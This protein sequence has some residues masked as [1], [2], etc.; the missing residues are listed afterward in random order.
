MTTTAM[1]HCESY[2]QH[3]PNSAG[4]DSGGEGEIRREI[5]REGGRQRKRGQVEK[6]RQPWNARPDPPLSSVAV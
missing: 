3:L 2:L 6:Q 1:M 4:N 5:Q